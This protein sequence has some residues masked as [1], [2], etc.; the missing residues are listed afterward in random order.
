V[1][2]IQSAKKRVRQAI[3][4]RA[5]N[6]G[7][8]SA[9]RTAVKTLEAN[10]AGGDKAAATESFRA[11]ARALDKAVSKGHI[12]KNMASRKKSRLNALV[13]GM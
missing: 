6:M 7:Q 11:A 10:I 5:R 3:T 12:H 4:R 2:N 9:M 8:R 1:P 13:K